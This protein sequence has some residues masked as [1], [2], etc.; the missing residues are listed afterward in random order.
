MP[1]T[2]EFHVD[3]GRLHIVGE[4]GGESRQRRFDIGRASETEVTVSEDC[5]V[6]VHGD[7]VELRVENVAGLEV[8]IDSGSL[9]A[10]DID[11]NVEIHADN[12]DIALDS[13][14]GNVEIHIDSGDVEALGVVGRVEIS[15]D[16]SEITLQAT[17]ERVDVC[18]DS[19]DVVLDLVPAGNSARYEV[20]S[21]S[22]AVTIRLP[23]D[24]GVRAEFECESGEV[25]NDTEPGDDVRLNVCTDSGDI[26]VVSRVPAVG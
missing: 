19:G 13:V 10:I 20:N 25:V 22:G 18:T 3:S 17:S 1:R 8:H 2:I 15:A 12:T 23:A 21:D 16:S 24:V 11:G 5:R 6:E 14:V 7:S 9:E 26:T 4:P